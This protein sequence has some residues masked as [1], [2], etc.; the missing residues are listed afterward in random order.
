VQ[1]LLQKMNSGMPTREL[2]KVMLRDTGKNVLIRIAEEKK[3]EIH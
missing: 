1:V 2:I 3:R